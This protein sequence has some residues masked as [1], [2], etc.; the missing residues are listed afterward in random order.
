MKRPS[1]L[2]RMEVNCCNR[3]DRL[4]SLSGESLYQYPPF[5]QTFGRERVWRVQRTRAK[6]KTSLSNPAT[7][8]QVGVGPLCQGF[9][10]AVLD[11]FTVGFQPS[12]WNELRSYEAG[13]HRAVT[14]MSTPN[15]PNAFSSPAG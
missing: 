11:W 1:G 7:L 14:G 6:E 2:T 15:A 8:V 3:N 13:S 4:R 5:H 10:R 12:P 9:S